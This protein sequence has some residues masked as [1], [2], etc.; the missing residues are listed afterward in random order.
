M[1]VFAPGGRSLLPP[2]IGSLREAARAAATSNARI[3]GTAAVLVAQAWPKGELP[4]IKLDQRAAPDIA[5]VGR[6]GAAA[7]ASDSAP[8]PLYLRAPDATPQAN[9]RLP[10][11]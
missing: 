2:R 6:L 7:A 4:P 1:Q 11:R 8:K 3:V 10:R 5:W 9:A